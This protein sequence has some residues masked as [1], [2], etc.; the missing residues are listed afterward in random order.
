M[1]VSL[2]LAP[3][4][5]SSQIQVPR[6]YKI[7]IHAAPKIERRRA[8]IQLQRLGG[9]TLVWRIER[10]LTMSQFA[11]RVDFPM[12]AV[13]LG[14]HEVRREVREAAARY[15]EASRSGNR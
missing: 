9:Q 11:K 3:K 1:L 4:E 8:A 5:M 10:A 2:S 6:I 12:L 14:L 7:R 13:C 15:C